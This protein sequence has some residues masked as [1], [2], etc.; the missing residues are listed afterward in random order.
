TQRAHTENTAVQRATADDA[1]QWAIRLAEGVTDAE[2]QSEAH[3]EHDPQCH[4]EQST[5]GQPG[6]A[7]LMT[8][9]SAAKDQRHRRCHEEEADW[10]ASD[11]PGLGP[12]I[13]ADGRADDTA[14]RHAREAEA[15]H[16]PR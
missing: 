12:E 8:V 1:A 9:G 5:H 3:R 4:G 11:V 16:G 14:K 13:V 15:G 7:G 6:P 2:E 10:P